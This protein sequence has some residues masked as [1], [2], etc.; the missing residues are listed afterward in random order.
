MTL[1]LKFISSSSTDFGTLALAA[2]WNTQSYFFENTVLR[3]FVSLISP[4]IIPAL[5]L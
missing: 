2:K 3:A 4:K 1:D 5:D